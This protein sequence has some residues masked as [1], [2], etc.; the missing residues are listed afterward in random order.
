MCNVFGQE[1]AGSIAD[2]FRYR[3][4]VIK[5]LTGKFEPR[6]TKARMVIFGLV[7]CSDRNSFQRDTEITVTFNLNFADFFLLRW[8]DLAVNSKM[9]S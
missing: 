7:Q 8:I 2:E 4:N 5:I 3:N 9:I 6:L 1:Y